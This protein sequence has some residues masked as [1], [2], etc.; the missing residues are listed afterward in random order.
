MA[1]VRLTIGGARQK[2]FLINGPNPDFTIA[3]EKIAEW[4]SAP[5]HDRLLDLLDIVGAVFAADGMVTRG[6]LSRPNLGAGWRR[7]ISLDIAV[8][9][10]DFWSS[11]DV[12]FSLEDTIQFLTDDRMTFRFRRSSAPA[13]SSDYLDF[14]GATS[15]AGSPARIVLFSGGLDSLA[16]A[17]DALSQDTGRVILVTHRSA[18]KIISHQ[19]ELADA[20]KRRHGARVAYVPIKATRHGRKPVERTQ[21]SRSLLFAAFGYVIARTIGADRLSFFENGVVSHNLPISPQIIGT[22]AT[23]TTHPLA[24]RK[25]EAL[26]SLVGG[27]PFR[28]R[29]EFEWLTK[30]EVVA[31][32][33]E[34]GATDLIRVAVSCNEVF[35]RTR[36]MTHCGLCTQCLDRRFGILAAGLS[37]HEPE[38]LYETSVLFGER[39]EGRSRVISVEWARHAMRFA[40]MDLMAFQERFAGELARIARGNPSMTATEVVRRSLELHRRHGAAV[41]KALRHAAESHSE[42]LVTGNLDPTSLFRMV[43]SDANQVPALA[44]LSMGPRPPEPAKMPDLGSV[45]DD[46]DGRLR[47]VMSGEGRGSWIDVIG[48]G[49]IHG[50]PAGPAMALKPQFLADRDAGLQPD[51]HHYVQAGRLVPDGGPTKQ[52]VFQYVKRCRAVLAECYRE[53][54]GAP[55][56]GPLLIQNRK[57]RGYRLD[58]RIVIVERPDAQGGPPD[59]PTLAA[60]PFD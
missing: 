50:A 13:V 30:A 19:D 38:D 59:D 48:L 2:A 39:G 54:Y 21:R 57:S 37:D 25:F 6:G 56:D 58:P 9:D 27:E 31:K 46:E 10:P 40:A 49:A 8:R 4:G 11:E 45:D 51:E 16:G 44:E 7:E 5:V 52:A 12:V 24:L 22:M 20:L 3:T 35:G 42:A 43:V 32:L 18:Q 1:E 34:H 60:Q 29:N 17:L 55:P 36:E 28:V 47:V 26:L 33:R 53:K 14:A 15:P 23:R 41:I